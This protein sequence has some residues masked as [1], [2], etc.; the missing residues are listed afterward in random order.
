MTPLIPNPVE[1]VSPLAQTEGLDAPGLADELV[2]G[3]TAER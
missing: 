3:V 2:P 1:P